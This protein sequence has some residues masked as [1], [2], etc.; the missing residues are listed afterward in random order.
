MGGRALV[1]DPT[2]QRSAMS[3][4]WRRWPQIDR[5]HSETLSDRSERPARDLIYTLDLMNLFLVFVLFI[6]FSSLQLNLVTC[7]MM[8]YIYGHSEP[9][10][11]WLCFWSLWA[12]S[13]SVPFSADPTD[14][15]Q[16][17]I[18]FQ[19]ETTVADQVV[20]RSSGYIWPLLPI[21]VIGSFRNLL[22]SWTAAW[23]FGVLRYSPTW[24]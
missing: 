15:T 20:R 14:P 12:F 21:Y 6:R 24:L 5:A 4:W 16:D 1:D 9:P 8:F 3:R 7:Q 11:A 13:P 10:Q 18:C 22:L 2:N 23:C 17:R 19:N